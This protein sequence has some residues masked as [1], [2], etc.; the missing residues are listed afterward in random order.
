MMRAEKVH[1]K[2]R[3]DPWHLAKCVRKDLAVASKK[4]E[5]GD[6]LPWTAAVVNHLWWC[7]AT[8]D[9]DQL[10]CQEKWKS[11]VYHVGDVHEW[12]DLQLFSACDHDELTNEQRRKK[13]WLPI[14]SPP[15]NGLKEVAWKATSSTKYCTKSPWK[16]RRHH[17]KACVKIS[18]NLQVTGYC[19]MVPHCKQ[20]LLSI[21][22]YIQFVSG[23][24]E[25]LVV[26]KNIF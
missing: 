11:V 23:L 9:G 8:S 18:I 15:H 25:W 21:Y 4:R 12:P 24:H 14:R 3:L 16:Q 7:A 6:L 2:H 19:Y 1:I 10:L 26:I 17:C 22:L 13:V 5:W 20:S